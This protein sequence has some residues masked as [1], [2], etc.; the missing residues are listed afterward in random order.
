M[1]YQGAQDSP[2]Q[3]RRSQEKTHNLKLPDT[4]ILLDQHSI[5]GVEEILH[6]M[7]VYEGR[8]VWPLVWPNYVQGVEI[9]NFTA[10]AARVERGQSTFAGC[11]SS[12]EMRENP[13]PSGPESR[14]QVGC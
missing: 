12:F 4:K 2:V 7:L 11:P 8:A 6:I 3:W 5:V 13:P 10:C 1:F 14:D 9:D